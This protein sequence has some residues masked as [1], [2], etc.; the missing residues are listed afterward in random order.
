MSH[1]LFSLSAWEE[2][3]Y[4]QVEGVRRLLRVSMYLPRVSLDL[5]TRNFSLRLSFMSVM[6]TRDAWI[7][8]ATSPMALFF[9]FSLNI[10]TRVLLMVRGKLE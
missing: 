8:L 4:F 2:E 5:F 10:A 3:E 6:K 7:L 1:W 9:I